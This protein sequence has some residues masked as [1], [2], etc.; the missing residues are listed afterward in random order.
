M[1]IAKLTCVHMNVF[2]INTTSLACKQHC[3]QNNV[4]MHTRLPSHGAHR[5]QLR[6]QVSE[7]PALAVPLSPC[8]LISRSGPYGSHLL[9]GQRPCGAR[10]QACVFSTVQPYCL[11]I[12]IQ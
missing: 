6:G 1:A 10:G 4:L 12:R 11:H 9:P 8:V 7:W 5:A 3:P 2:K